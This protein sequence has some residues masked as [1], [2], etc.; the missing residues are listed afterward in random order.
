MAHL[1][2]NLHYL[3]VP[4]IVGALVVLA[5]LFLRWHLVLVAIYSRDRGRRRRASR[6]YE[7]SYARRKST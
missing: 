4:G 3:A 1:I 7:V 6:L 2:E 5:R